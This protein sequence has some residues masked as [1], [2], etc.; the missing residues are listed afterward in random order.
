[1]APIVEHKY[2]VLVTMYYILGMSK[3]RMGDQGVHVRGKDIQM[4]VLPGIEMFQGGKNNFNRLVYS[5][6]GEDKD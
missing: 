6:I 1:M 4:P 5:N 3:N 2:R